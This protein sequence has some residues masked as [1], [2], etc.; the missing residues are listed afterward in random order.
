MSEETEKKSLKTQVK[1]Q[2]GKIILVGAISAAVATWNYIIIPFALAYG[3]TLPPVPLEQV[4]SHI[5]VGI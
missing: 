5:M 3:I 1:D 2:K 4:I